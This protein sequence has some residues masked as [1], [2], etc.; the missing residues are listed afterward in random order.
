[1]K[2]FLTSLSVFVLVII[3]QSVAFAS[4]APSANLK[5]DMGIPLSGEILI[6]GRTVK[7][8]APYIRGDEGTVMVPLRAV[9]E[10]LGL[11]VSWNEAD[12]SIRIGADM[13]IFIGKDYYIINDG[14]PVTFG[15]PPEISAGFTYVPISFFQNA[16][17]GYLAFAQD[18]RVMIE[19]DIKNAS[20]LP[21][22]EIIENPFVYIPASGKIYN[23]SNYPIAGIKGSIISPPDGITVSAAKDLIVEKLRQG[24]IPG[25]I[26]SYIN[27]SEITVEQ[28]WE[29]NKTQLFC[30][31]L[32]SRVF[33]IIA[34]FRD[35]KLINIY[36]G[37]NFLAIYLADLNNDGS[38]EIIVNDCTPANTGNYIIRV[39]GIEDLKGYK[40]D[41]LFK[42]DLLLA[43]DETGN[44]LI[45]Y[46]G[47]IYTARDIW[48]SLTGHLLLRDNQ[49]I[50]QD[51]TG[52]TVL[53]GESG[54]Y[55]LRDSQYIVEVNAG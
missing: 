30:A 11:N 12:K 6:N 39:F 26:N 10:Q 31:G 50:V 40:I 43:I 22:I 48:V 47:G 5:T 32:S 20:E 29:I 13:Y 15:L 19:N 3:I 25:D 9:A 44:N 17:T 55:I 54:H 16:L 18:G 33:T 21:V 52:K 14:A 27:V 1:L 34:I 4:E 38:Y 42:Y 24:G 51:N 36:F 28:I 23:S 49:L 8:P 46:K 53:T 2:K 35:G 37:G 41:P 45:V 7:A